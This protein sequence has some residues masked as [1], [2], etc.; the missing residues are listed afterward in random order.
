MPVFHAGHFRV[1]WHVLM[2]AAF[3]ADQAPD[4]SEVIIISPWISDVTTSKSGWS[5]SWLYT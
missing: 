2:D 3:R 4:D 1:F 5:D